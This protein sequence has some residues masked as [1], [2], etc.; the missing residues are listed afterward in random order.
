MR[1]HWEAR[2]P[3]VLYEKYLTS[4]KLLDAKSKKE[5]EDKIGALLAKE[6]EFAENSPMPPAELAEEGVY[7][8]GDECH[9]IRAKWERP[10][11]EVTPPKSSVAAV[12][13]VPGFGAGKSSG[14]ANAP[15]HFGDAPAAAEKPVS[16][17]KAA[18]K[19]ATKAAAK[20]AVKAAPARASRKA[21][22]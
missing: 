17:R 12:W 6:R 22:R 4:E 2:D 19:I 5:I 14:G 18:A 16:E 21:R 3:I 13:S 15:I 11:A 9:K 7:C 10:V 8:T 20:K 1:A